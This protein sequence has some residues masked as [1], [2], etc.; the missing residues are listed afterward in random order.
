MHEMCT[1]K[2]SD[3]LGVRHVCP[4]DDDSVYIAIGAHSVGNEQQ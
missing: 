1:F 3:D 2:S 4:C